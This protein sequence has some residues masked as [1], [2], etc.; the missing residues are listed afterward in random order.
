MIWIYITEPSMCGSFRDEIQTYCRDSLNSCWICCMTCSPVYHR[1]RSISLMLS[2]KD[3][4]LRVEFVRQAMAK[5]FLSNRNFLVGSW[6]SVGI[7]KLKSEGCRIAATGTGVGKPLGWWHSVGRFPSV[8]WQESTIGTSGRQWHVH[9][10]R[11]SQG[12]TMR[13]WSSTLPWSPFVDSCRWQASVRPAEDLD[14]SMPTLSKIRLSVLGVNG[15]FESASNSAKRSMFI[16]MLLMWRSFAR[17]N[18]GELT[19]AAFEGQCT[20]EWAS[21]TGV[22]N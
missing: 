9:Q 2:I 18:G 12:N 14:G 6:S 19:R 8:M 22:S 16:S 11:I 15:M 21:V 13:L 10:S 4:F 3:W 1:C 20:A 5:H 17:F 7:F